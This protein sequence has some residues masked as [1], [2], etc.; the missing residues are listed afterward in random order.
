MSLV[1]FLNQIKPSPPLP[2]A[3]IH[4]IS[5]S[6]SPSPSPLSHHHIISLLLNPAFHFTPP[7]SMVSFRWNKPY[8]IYTK[9]QIRS[10]N[11]QYPL[12]LLFYCPM[13]GIIITIPPLLFHFQDWRFNTSFYF[14]IL[15]LDDVVHSQNKIH[16][17]QT[18]FFEP[19]PSDKCS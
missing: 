13:I 3:T 6:P 18:D 17:L 8:I 5:P 10:T 19:T 16:P 11:L 7:I 12:N 2:Q 14:S 4:H 1:P 9:H 15:A